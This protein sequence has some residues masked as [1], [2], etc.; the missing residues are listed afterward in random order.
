GA[1]GPRGAARRAAAL[2]GPAA[3]APLAAAVGARSV[4]RLGSDRDA[5]TRV[6]RRALVAWCLTPC[7]LPDAPA[8]QTAAPPAS[9][10]ARA[11]RLFGTDE[12][13]PL[14]PA[15]D[16]TALGKDPGTNRPPHPGAPRYA[17]S[18]GGS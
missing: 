18:G 2:I 10:A 9:P 12:P 11:P 13:L 7:A 16:W 3:G 15:T 17:S 1:P 8:P 14:T 5:W 6:A 4:R